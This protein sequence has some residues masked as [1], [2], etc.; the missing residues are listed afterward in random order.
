MFNNNLRNRFALFLI[1]LIAPLAG[2]SAAG[3]LDMGSTST[4]ATIDTRGSASLTADIGTRSND[5]SFALDRDSDEVKGALGPQVSADNVSDARDLKTFA[6]TELRN[7]ENLAS[8]AF[9]PDNVG[10][11]YDERARLLGIIP[12]TVEVGVVAHD[13]GTVDFNYPWYS[14]LLVTNRGDIE[15]AIKSEVSAYISEHSPGTPNTGVDASGSVSSSSALK[16]NARNEALLAARIQA[17]LRAHLV[18]EN[19]DATSTQGSI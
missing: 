14:F 19:G 5:Q 6:A 11:T 2:V 3:L 9:G 15:S 17:I 18:G 12:T 16:L 7:D 1:T 10:V 4:G 8:M 13:D